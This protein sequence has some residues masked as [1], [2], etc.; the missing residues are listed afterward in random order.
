MAAS[1]GQDHEPYLGRAAASGA[2][3]A[4]ATVPGR[5]AKRHRIWQKTMF[6]LVG[7]SVCVQQLSSSSTCFWNTD[8][9]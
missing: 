8:S 2:Q 4:D 3:R 5:A 7:G 9:A 1:G 6:D